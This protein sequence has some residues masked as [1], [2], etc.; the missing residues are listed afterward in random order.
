MNHIFITNITIEKIRHLSG[1]E[2]PVAEDG[3]K[4]LIITGKNGSGKTSL[5]DALA[6]Y[7]NSIMISDELETVEDG[8]D[9]RLSQPLD[10][11]RECFAHGEM[12]VAYYEA[13]RVFQTTQSTTVEKV[14]FKDSYTINEKPRMNLVKYLLDMKMTQALALNAGKMEK[15]ESIQKWFDSFE[16]LLQKIFTEDELKL[17]FDED[18]FLFYI[19]VPGKENFDFNTLSSGYAA[20]LDIII[21]LMLRMEKHK[22][23]SFLYDLPGIVLIDEIETHLHLEMQKNVMD[24]LTTTFPNIQF[25]VSTHSPFVINSTKNT[26]IFDIENHKLVK[27]GLTDVPYSGIVEGYFHA[28]EM[29]NELKEKYEQYKSLVMQKELSDEDYE[30]VAELELYLDEIPD[31][32]A[33]NIATEYKRLKLE[34]NNREDI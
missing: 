7:L 21:D 10:H 15:V 16:M 6:K 14:E 24:L 33:L 31:Y 34:F 12:I 22:K 25:V 11:M 4:H 19:E 28:N 8:L 23:K 9:I 2:I 5:L 13:D 26:T 30:K 29:S 1:I 20:V 17:R 18:S 32:L 27:N 3:L